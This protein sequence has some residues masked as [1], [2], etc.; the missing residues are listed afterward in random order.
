[1][2]PRDKTTLI[3][4]NSLL[5]C[6]FRLQNYAVWKL[7]LIPLKIRKE[8]GWC[9][10][11]SCFL[12]VRNKSVKHLYSVFFLAIS[13]NR[14]LQILKRARLRGREIS[15]RAWISIIFAGKRYSGRH[16]TTSFGENAVVAIR[17]EKFVIVMIYGK[18]CHLFAA[19]NTTW[20]QFYPINPNEPERIVG[21]MNEV[22]NLRQLWNLSHS[23]IPA[24][25]IH[26]M[27]I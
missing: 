13:L 7:V 12:L 25:W 4:H 10:P 6:F 22:Y 5:L 14:D 1:M 11:S 2:R 23:C 20:H 18:F 15:A 21:I 17:F 8:R 16:S 9:T 3:L 26:F 27:L 24:A 19:W